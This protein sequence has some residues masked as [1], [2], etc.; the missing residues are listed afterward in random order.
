MLNREVGTNPP[1]N[2]TTTVSHLVATGANGTAG[3]TAT[4]AMAAVE[5]GTVPGMVPVVIN[6]L[7]GTLA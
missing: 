3:T 7:Q 6:G 1:A 4:T 5:T 2:A